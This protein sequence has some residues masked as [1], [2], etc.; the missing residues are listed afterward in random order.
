MNPESIKDGG[1]AFP[2]HD[3]GTPGVFAPETHTGMKLRDYFAAK[4]MQGMLANSE[5][6]GTSEPVLRALFRDRKLVCGY[7]ELAYDIA[8]AMLRARSI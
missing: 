6:D 1:P 5:N 4:A 3:P 2:S 8:E 7:A